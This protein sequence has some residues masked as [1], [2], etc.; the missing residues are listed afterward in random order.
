MD[1]AY[2]VLT[3]QGKLVTN[4]FFL[5]LEEAQEYIKFHQSGIHRNQH[6]PHIERLTRY[7]ND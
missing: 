4:Q 1:K 3:G 5:T 6:K 7:E 2:I